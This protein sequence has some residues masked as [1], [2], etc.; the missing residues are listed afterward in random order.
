MSHAGNH[1]G[2]SDSAGGR[3]YGLIAEFET[4]SALVAAAGRTHRAGYQRFDAYAPF[5][6]E[7][8]THAMGHHRSRLPLRS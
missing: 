7:E 6:I 8:L 3:I 4:P 1:S 5:P 2:T